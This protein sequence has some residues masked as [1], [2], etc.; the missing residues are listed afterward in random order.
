MAFQRGKGQ[1]YVHFLKMCLPVAL[2]SRFSSQ[3]TALH[4]A[5]KEGHA[6]AVRLLL[7]YG[8]KILLNK[9]VASFF[10]E[11]IHNRRKDVVSAVILH[12][13]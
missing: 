7:D 11:A 9:A 4:L 3:N 12:K 8:A 5:A 13:R 2:L 6:K 10:H 1:K